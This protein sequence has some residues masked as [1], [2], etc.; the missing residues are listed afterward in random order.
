MI[1]D[2]L[3]QRINEAVATKARLQDNVRPKLNQ[4]G[5]AIRKLVSE[6]GADLSE[7]RPLADIIADLRRSNP[8]LRDFNRRLDLATYDLRKRLWWD[9]NMM[10]AYATD[11]AER[12]FRMEIKPRL[13][14]ARSQ[15]DAKAKQ[16]MTFVRELTERRDDMAR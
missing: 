8:T 7:P 2:T 5:E 6:L 15:A 10:T 1:Q 13:D 14:D 16:V 4:L 9:A 12:T 3:K 11:R